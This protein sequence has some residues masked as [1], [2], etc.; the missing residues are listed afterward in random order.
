M[1]LF[2]IMFVHGNVQGI[3]TIDWD[4][5]SMLLHCDSRKPKDWIC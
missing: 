5:K 1:V 3:E 2:P 4:D